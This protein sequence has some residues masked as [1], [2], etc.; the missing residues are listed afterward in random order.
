MLESCDS[1]VEAR[2]FS[3]P[4]V[5]AYWTKYG[6]GEVYVKYRSMDI[7]VAAMRSEK[8]ASRVKTKPFI[9]PTPNVVFVHTITLMLAGCPVDRTTGTVAVCIEVALFENGL[10]PIDMLYAP[11]DN[12]VM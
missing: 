9:H 6:E 1:F 12:I 2:V 11:G 10:S 8:S 4:L 7:P 3:S 5:D